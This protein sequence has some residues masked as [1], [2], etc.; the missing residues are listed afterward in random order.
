MKENSPTEWLK[1]AR[2]SVLVGLA[3]AALLPAAAACADSKPSQPRFMIVD[4][5][6]MTDPNPE[7]TKKV[8][9]QLELKGYI[10]AY[11][12]TEQVYVHFYRQLPKYDSSVIII[13]SHSTNLT[14]R[15]NTIENADVEL[16][17]SQPYSREL[18][19]DDQ[20]E[21]ELVLTSF[22]D[23]KQDLYFGITSKFVENEMDG[24]FKKGSI[25]IV[26]GCNGLSNTSFADALFKKGV[27]TYFGFDGSVTAEFTDKATAVLVQHLFVDQMT[28]QKARDATVLE[29]G[30]DPFYGGTLLV[31]QNEK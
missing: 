5:L 25:V 3:G 8:G 24:K 15:N 12:P 11:V 10:I 27:E 13:R 26:M 31:L 23:N 18:Y 14:L 9:S 1:R 19:I 30:N 2:S 7:F 29:V 6:A 16:F 20:R 28:P 17:T 22:L 21:G 4:Q